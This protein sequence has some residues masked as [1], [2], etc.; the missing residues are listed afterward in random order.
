M[1]IWFATLIVAALSLTAGPAAASTSASESGLVITAY[2]YDPVQPVTTEVS[3]RCEPTGGTHPDAEAACATLEQVD[4]DFDALIPLG[5]FC[6]EYFQPVAVEV[7]GKWRDRT[8]TFEHVYG[9]RCV[10]EDQS[11]GVFQLWR[12]AQ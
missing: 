9:N 3:L 1:R 5:M 6:P 4:G 8:V 12:P 2:T 11:E 7:V 10:A